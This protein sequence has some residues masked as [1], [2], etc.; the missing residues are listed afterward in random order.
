MTLVVLPL[1]SVRTTFWLFL[2]VFDER[3]VR[4]TLPVL[5]LAPLVAFLAPWSRIAPE[6][7]VDL[8]VTETVHVIALLLRAS[9]QTATY[10]TVLVVAAVVLVVVVVVVGA[11]N[12]TGAGVAV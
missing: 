8:G 2:S 12:G 3:T 11:A 5:L 9:A 1:L 6:N 10:V 7:T 4:L